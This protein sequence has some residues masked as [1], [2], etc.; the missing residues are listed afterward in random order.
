[1]TCFNSLL[2]QLSRVSEFSITFSQ[3]SPFHSR[4][5]PMGI[6]NKSTIRCTST[7]SNFVSKQKLTTTNL[8]HLLLFIIIF[9]Y[10]SSTRLLS[11]VT[12]HFNTHNTISLLYSCIWSDSPMS[13]PFSR[14]VSMHFQKRFNHPISFKILSLF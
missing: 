2:G 3:Q 11:N 12:L 4:E 8:H 10:T 9:S 6:N 7:I 1:M 5:T 13:R 14:V